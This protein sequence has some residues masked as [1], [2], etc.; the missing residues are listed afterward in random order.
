VASIGGVLGVADSVVSLLPGASVSVSTSQAVQ[1]TRMAA[2]LDLI[3]APLDGNG[4]NNAAEC[5]PSLIPVPP[6]R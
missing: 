3:G 4:A 2:R 5:V 6:G 1:P